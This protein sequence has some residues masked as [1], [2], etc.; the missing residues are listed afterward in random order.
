[1]AA[2]PR[3]RFR[4]RPRRSDLAALRKLIDATEVFY[5]EERAIALELLEERL[6]RGARSGYFFFFAQLRGELVGYC[7]WGPVPLTRGSYDL[8]WIAVAPRRQGLGLGRQ[9]LTLAEQAASR[10]S[11]ARVY[12][13]TSS[14]P[15]YRRTRRFY[16]SAGYR[17]VARL[18]DFYAPGDHKIVFCK[19]IR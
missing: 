15:A 16:G 3:I 14:R 2:V 1:M 11:A 9:L 12:I 18:R 13:E 6:R 5:P 4:S 8:Y 17:Q 10:R 7:A 19:T